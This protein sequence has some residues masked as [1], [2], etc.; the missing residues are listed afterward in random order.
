MI[1]FNIKTM[2]AHASLK[3]SVILPLMNKNLIFFQITINVVMEITLVEI[4]KILE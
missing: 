3:N 4:K 2:D 1:V